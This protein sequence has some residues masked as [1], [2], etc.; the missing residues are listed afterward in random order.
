MSKRNSQEF[1]QLAHHF[2]VEPVDAAKRILKEA[3][4]GRQV[5]RWLRRAARAL[6]RKAPPA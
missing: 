5:P 6:T 4:L 3:R 1:S 2:G